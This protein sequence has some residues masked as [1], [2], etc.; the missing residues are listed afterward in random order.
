[1]F[2][3]Y[4]EGGLKGVRCR[5]AFFVPFSGFALFTKQNMSNGSTSFGSRIGC[6]HCREDARESVPF[7]YA[8]DVA[9][10]ELQQQLVAEDDRNAVQGCE[11]ALTGAAELGLA[12]V[13]LAY[14]TDF[15][16]VADVSATAV[17]AAGLTFAA[18]LARRPELVSR[19]SSSSR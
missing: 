12:G 6:L 1:M 16:V 18:F 2:L 3:A 14:A 7:L 19:P 11:A 5:E 15:E 4:S 17:V 8:F 13:A 9:Y 10:V